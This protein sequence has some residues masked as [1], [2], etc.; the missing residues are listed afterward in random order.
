[1]YPNEPKRIHLANLPTPIQKLEKLTALFDGPEIYI[2]R[3]DLTGVG[4]SGNKVRKLEYLLADAKEK[5]ADTLITCGGI[6]S[7]HARATAIAA[8]Q[9][10]MSSVL[11]L[12]GES[13]R[14]YDGNVLLGR[15][16]DAQIR[17]VTPEQYAERIDQIMEEVAGELREQG[18]RPY[19]IPEGG[20]NSI[21]VWGYIRAGGEIRDQ[22]EEMDLEVDVI[23][24]A[25]GSGGTLAGLVVGRKLNN[26]KARMVGFNVCDTAE[27]FQA[28][29]GRLVAE[30][31]KRYR[32]PV[33]VAEDEIEL[34]NGYVGRGYALSR[35][36]ELALIRQVAKAEGIF[37]DPVYTG[38]ALFGLAD[39]IHQGR[40]KTGEKVLFLHTG[41]IYGLFTSEKRQG[42]F[43]GGS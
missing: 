33:Q 26:L 28:L 7:N 29:I 37:L 42:L 30:T 24:T 16:V 2:K 9:N 10:D 18:R 23:V 35:P 40:F 27:H 20:S 19:V 11:V 6:Q 17:L 31:I 32:L 34:I 5:E 1:M 38:K 14:P 43:P 4:L 25:V 39:Q 22:L 8:A 36:E 41:G 21:G 12:R 13:E 3:D 15:L